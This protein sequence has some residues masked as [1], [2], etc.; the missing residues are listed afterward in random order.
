MEYTILRKYFYHSNFLTCDFILI[1]L[2]YS[3][4]F[5]I[6]LVVGVEVEYEC[7][8]PKICCFAHV[9]DRVEVSL[10]WCK[11]FY[12]VEPLIYGGLKKKNCFSDIHNF[13]M[14]Q[15]NYLK[16]SSGS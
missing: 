8:W 10:R 1:T 2:Y 14:T 4:L 5:S 7:Y 16:V 6:D 9:C 3:V 11:Q 13:T 12:E 15:E